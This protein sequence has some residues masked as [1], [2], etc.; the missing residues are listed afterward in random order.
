MLADFLAH[1]PCKLVVDGMAGTCGND[2][3]LD[4][5]TDK[6]HVTDDVEQLMPGTLVLPHE[7]LV[8]DVANLLGIHVWHL[9]YVGQL[10][11]LFLCSLALVDDDGIVEVASLDEVCLKKGNNVADKY[12][13]A[14][15]GCCRG[16][17]TGCL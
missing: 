3:S 7:R 16:L 4:R 6:C 13:C 11:E 5:F 9:K 10:V 2:A 15:R 17:Q 14:R 8:L 12:E 1:E